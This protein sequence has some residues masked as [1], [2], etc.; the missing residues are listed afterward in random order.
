MSVVTRTRPVPLHTQIRRLIETQ[1]LSGQLAPGSQ[2]PTEQEYAG[3]FGVSIAPVRQALLDL[4]SAGHLVRIK[5]RGTFVRQ[6]KV[7]ESITLLASFT[8]SLRARGVD[9]A[10]Q[11]LDLARVR[12][13][14]PVADSL[15][16][17]LGGPVIRLRR[18]AFIYG[19]PAALLDAYLPADRF[20]GLL[21]TDGWN[22]GRSLYRTL[23]S[24]FSTRI[25]Q[26]RSLLE[27]VQCDDGQ[28]ELLVVPRG[29]PALLVHSV[30]VEADGRPIEVTWVLFR[31]DRFRFSING[32][33]REDTS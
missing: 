3:L 23:E 11:L 24:D 20:A 30:T 27:V 6:P 25:D 22:E 32:V 8:E 2:L 12:A 14:A 33:P 21:A 1:I 7:E 15:G 5:G 17:R 10:M 18:L 29:T 16:I 9:F 28:A 19:E 26:A 31:A 4:A 13:D